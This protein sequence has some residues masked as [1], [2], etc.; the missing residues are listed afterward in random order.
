MFGRYATIHYW[1]GRFSVLILFRI[2]RPSPDLQQLDL[3]PEIA[4]DSEA[5]LEEDLVVDLVALPWVVAPAVAAV[6]AARSMFPTFV[7]H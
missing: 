2:V 5:A 7:P 6:V 3:Q 4:A 1:G